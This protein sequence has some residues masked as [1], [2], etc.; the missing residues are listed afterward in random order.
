MLRALS[1]LLILFPTLAAAASGKLAVDAGFFAISAKAG[2]ETA[3]ISS[4]SAFRLGYLYPLAE[5]V[6]LA[7]QYSILLADF[8][9][10]DLGYGLDVGANYY[11][12]TSANDQSFK[13]ESFEVRTYDLWK[14]YAGLNFH[15]RNFQSVKNSYAGFGVALGTERYF[16]EEISFRGEARYIGLSG[17]G[18][19][20]ATELSLFLGM[21][22][23]L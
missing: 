2:G 11:F 3:S 20:T 19:S 21:V 10:G 6:E 9:G 17:S 18:E 4:P 8:S 14:P 7:F 23:R 13:S 16:S 15:Q 5:K 22:F 1:L 12:F